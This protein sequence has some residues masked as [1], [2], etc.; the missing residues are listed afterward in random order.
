MKVRHERPQSDLAFKVR[1][2]LKLTLETGK[3]VA[4]DEWSLTGFT[5][6]EDADI[7]PKVGLLSIPFQG[8][9]V[10]F[11]TRFVNGDGPREL[12]FDGLTGRQRETLA[13][14]YRSI[15]S[16]KMASSEDVITSLDTP[17]DLVPMGETEEEEA[18]GKAKSKSR[19][20]RILWNVTF[21]TVMAF[22]IFGVIGNQVFSRLSQV[23]LEHA[24]IVAPIIVHRSTEAGFVDKV[25]VSPGD[26][27]SRG[28][29]LV[30]L[31]L[32]DRDAELDDVREDINFA[33]RELETAETRLRAHQGVRSDERARLRAAF[34]AE[35][36]QHDHRDYFVDGDYGDLAAAREALDRFDRESRLAQ[37]TYF[38][39]ENELKRIY[40]EREMRQ[41][42]LKRDLGNIKD[43]MEA[44][45]IYALADGVV[46]DVEVFEDQHAA[47][48]TT[49]VVIEE[50]TPRV[51]RAW[52]NE[53]RSDAIYLG[54]PTSIRFNDGGGTRS[55][56]GRITDMTAG[57]DPTVSDEFGV[58]VT[59]KL[60][61]LSTEDLR[62]QFR[63]DA[64]VTVTARK[65]WDWLTKW[66]QS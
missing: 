2:P 25:H 31:D 47:R 58:I 3:V 9:D 62:S 57:I 48:G 66:W 18:Q 17:V 6:P 30:E 56:P 32:P 42:R 8:V 59:V 41:S 36:S 19:L 65:N 20:L 10:Q 14:F 23:T 5:Y 49:F 21:Y 24:R 28:D 60:D 53:A 51:A 34:L 12:R 1:A 11:D 55:L 50:Y 61:D 38:D 26:L 4:I 29:L 33:E 52:L 16:G 63:P 27:V 40:D 7:L 37:G 43:S 39:L 46:Q 64:P 45:H 35:V 44:V 54:M 13:V 22:L 15:L